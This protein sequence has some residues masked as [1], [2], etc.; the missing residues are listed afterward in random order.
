[1]EK[2]DGRL[3]EIFEEGLGA[4][5]AAAATA[6]LVERSYFIAGHSVRLL[7]A[8][9][10]LVEPITRALAHHGPCVAPPELT[11]YLGD[12]S[13]TAIDLPAR[14][15]LPTEETGP[16][17]WMHRGARMRARFQPDYDSLHILDT[18]RDFALFWT[19]DAR[20]IRFWEKSAPLLLIF[21]WWMALRSRH[22][23][24]G[25]AIGKPDGG[26]LLVGRGGAGKSTTAL[27]CLRSELNYAGDDY[28]LIALDP[29]PFA[30]NLYNSAKIEAAS[31][32][33]FKTLRDFVANPD[34][35][36]AE[37]A[38]VF[39]HECLPE[40]LS[41]GFPIRAV[42]MP[43]VAGWR[44]TAIEPASPAAALAALAPSTLFQLRDR[45]EASFTA[46]AA[47]LRK[48]PCYRLDLGTDLTQIAPA[49][50][51]LLS[52]G[53]AAPKPRPLV[54]VVVPVYNGARFLAAAI[55]SALAQD[56][57]PVEVIVVD[58]GSD[59]GSAAIARSF[60]GV[61]YVYQNNQGPAAARNAGIREARGEFIAFLDT[62]D[63]M[64]PNK[65]GAQAN[66]LLQNSGVGCALS[67]REIFCE[68]GVEP[69]EWLRD[70]ERLRGEFAVGDAGLEDLRAGGM[71]SVIVRRQALER[72]GGFDA[73]LRHVEDIDWLLRVRDAGVK[74]AVLPQILWRRRIHG[75][76]LSYQRD[77][78]EQA[79]L[80]L[81]RKRIDRRRGAADLSGRPS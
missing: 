61:R 42:L 19:G 10:A 26:V 36:P 22:L 57:R 2:A 69:P 56:Y 12:S 72:A 40:K 15:G 52:R 55:E 49:I 17:G 76:N 38:L 51:Q 34:D 46:M 63:L 71:S 81:M 4:W 39:L 7:F 58:D 66:Y 35:L 70:D 78:I 33:D 67:G 65:I 24:H 32:G 37:K 6:G 11:I 47:L 64:L 48:V 16:A 9:G 77:R 50:L 59:D 30:F 60:E 8:G 45:D 28:H 44:E 21:H 14:L 31:L 3:V 80:M 62:D 18:S 41:A 54:S 5:E 27:A 68:P 74:I 53:P 73:E 1:V 23:V 43:R 29:V 13:S 75:G 20:R 79:W 25:A